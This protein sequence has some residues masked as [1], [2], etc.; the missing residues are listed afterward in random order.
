MTLKCTP[1]CVPLDHLQ[2]CRLS[3]HSLPSFT[4]NN[5][6]TFI[7]VVKQALSSRCARDAVSKSCHNLISSCSDPASMP[8]VGNISS[9]VG[10]IAAIPRCFLTISPSY[11]NVLH[12]WAIGASQRLATHQT[13]GL[14]LSQLTK[15][16]ST[17][18]PKLHK[19][20]DSWILFEQS[21]NPVTRLACVP[22]AGESSGTL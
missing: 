11:P 17:T 3:H 12:N 16:S 7:S 14:L 4:T 19:F 13:E 8:S 1:L 5:F 10:R 18:V 15:I 21:W 2:Q 9:S 20:F 22:S 6:L